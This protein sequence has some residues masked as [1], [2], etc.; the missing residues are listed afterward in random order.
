MR[1]L[2]LSGITAVWLL[3]AAPAWAEDAIPEAAL[4]DKVKLLGPKKAAYLLRQLNL[5]EEQAAQAQGLIDSILTESESGKTL[6]IEQVRQLWKEIEAAKA[7]ED[8]AKVD[9]LSA[10]LQQLG[11]DA[12]DDSEFYDNLEPQLNAEQKKLLRTAQARL[13][14]NPSGALRPIDLLRAAND[15]KL[16]EQQRTQL[17]AAH[18]GT[19]KILYPSLRPDLKL[20]LKMIN[21]FNTEIRQLLNPEQR[22]KYDR[23]VLELRPDLIDRGLRI[24]VE[25]K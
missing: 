23:R 10:Q 2:L 3:A 21:F 15:L 20:K 14:Q 22:A 4:N 17:R 7:A 9:E 6:D 8:Q 5:G 13:D 24:T 12:T 19:R 18:D 16:T 11:K 25:K 1:K